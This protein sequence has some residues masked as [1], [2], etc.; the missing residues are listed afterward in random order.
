MNF[1]VSA[2]DAPRSKSVK[3]IKYTAYAPTASFGLKNGLEGRCPGVAEASV[4]KYQPASA[5]C[6]PLTPRSMAASSF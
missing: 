6:S 5:S 1:F 2:K 3:K 4:A